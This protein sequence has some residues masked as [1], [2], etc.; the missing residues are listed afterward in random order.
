MINVKG[1]SG[2]SDS[3]FMSAQK[4]F[5]DK[6]RSDMREISRLAESAKTKKKPSWFSK[7]KSFLGIK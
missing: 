4:S 1:D 3:Q 5:Q 6:H 7:L 2:M